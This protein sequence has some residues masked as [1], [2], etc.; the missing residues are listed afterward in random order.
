M[1]GIYEITK[2]DVMSVYAGQAGKCMCGCKG[3]HT[4]NSDYVAAASKDRGYE[5]TQDEVNDAVV[6]R[7]LHMVKAYEEDCEVDGN[8]VSVDVGRKTYVLYLVGSIEAK[9]SA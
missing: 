4:Y 7:T 8:I 9:V 6:L 1:M 3:K 2:D 5:V